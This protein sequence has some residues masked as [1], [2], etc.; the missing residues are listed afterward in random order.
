MYLLT[1]YD[2]IRF[3]S[4]LD[5]IRGFEL[6]DEPGMRTMGTPP[7][8]YAILGVAPDATHDDIRRAFRRLARSSHPDASAGSRRD[9]T[10]FREILDAYRVLSDPSSR[11]EYD[12][13]NPAGRRVEVRTG[14]LEERRSDE[15]SQTPCVVCRGRGRRTVTGGC[16][17][18]AS[19]GVVLEIGLRRARRHR[20]AACRGSGRVLVTEPCPACSSPA[21]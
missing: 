10:E 9:S 11:S 17:S 7:S 8:L 13:S 19:T 5:E 21:P 18:C 1:T 3:V 4:R 20:C 12:R 15:A 2:L 16:S 6:V 14:P